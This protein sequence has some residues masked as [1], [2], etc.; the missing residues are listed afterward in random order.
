[1]PKTIWIVSEL[2]APDDAAT[3]HLMT[4]IAD[5]LAIESEDSDYSISV[6][7]AQPTYTSRGQKAPRHE[8]LNGVHINRCWSTTFSKDRLMLRGINVIT[9]MMTFFIKM[10]FR[11]RRGDR[12]LV[13]T[14]PP[15]LPF[16]ATLAAK[17]RGAKTYL[18]IH[19]IYPDVLVP[20]GFTQS[21]SLPYRVIDFATRRLYQSVNQIITIGRDM[22]NLVLQK[23]PNLNSKVS[24]ITNWA[25]DEMEP[26]L[27]ENNKFKSKT[28]DDNELVI[29][30]SGNMGR[31]HGLNIIAE[32]A[33][34]L[35][36]KGIYGVRWMMCGWG[37]GKKNF[38]QICKEKNLQSVVI[39]DPV[40]R[41]DLAALISAADISIISFIPEM[42]GISVPSRM[43]NILA[44]GCPIIG[45]TEPD[46]ELAQTI[47]DDD[48][49]WVS[50]PD[51]PELL[52]DLVV[53]LYKQRS[54]LADYQQRCRNAATTRYTKTNSIQAYHALLS[55]V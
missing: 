28:G 1:M 17:L 27:K 36:Q 52:A 12:V 41:K 38:E 13:V 15:P 7:C 31:T 44:A 51:K 46:S 40:P 3:A 33:A 11:F 37:S 19:D 25:D 18:L 5:G 26:V 6:I 10:L 43:Y 29:Q 42:S 48:L 47:F 39:L 34:I 4:Q 35:E 50:P 16:V 24:V 23:N 54:E 53:Q 21:A 55:K 8:I 49:G 14:N 45:I 2:F 32:A 30:Y 22:K 9:I 20:T